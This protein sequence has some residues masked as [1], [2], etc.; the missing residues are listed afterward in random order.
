MTLLSVLNINFFTAIQ[1][2]SNNKK[3]KIG[4]PGH[5][6][7]VGEVLCICLDFFFLPFL[8]SWNKEAATNSEKWAATFSMKH[9]P[10]SSRVISSELIVA[11]DIFVYMRDL[12]MCK[13]CK[14]YLI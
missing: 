2:K 8:Q 9:S 13:I 1:K 12:H 10:A 11:A 5:L 14:E 3:N 6:N 7:V 4:R